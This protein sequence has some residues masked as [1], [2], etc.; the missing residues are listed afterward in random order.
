MLSIG[1]FYEAVVTRLSICFECTLG[2]KGRGANVGPGSTEQ[3]GL[4]G[5][6]PWLLVTKGVE[7]KEEIMKPNAVLLLLLSCHTCPALFVIPASF[8]FPVLLLS[9]C[10][11]DPENSLA[12]HHPHVTPIVSPSWSYCWRTVLLLLSRTLL[13]GNE[14]Q[15]REG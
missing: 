12:D 3:D 11:R 9:A 14:E 15:R 6:G 7:M 8:F 1:L 2:A 5:R 4:D 10:W 13:V